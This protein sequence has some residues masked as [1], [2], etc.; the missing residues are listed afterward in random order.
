[1]KM[2]AKVTVKGVTI[3]VYQKHDYNIELYNVII[4]PP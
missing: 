3:T 2:R 1:M 4:I